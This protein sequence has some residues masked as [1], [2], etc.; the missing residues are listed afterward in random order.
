MLKELFDL[1][2]EQKS[3]LESLLK[4]SEEE[5]HIIINGEAD[6]LEDIV[7]QELRELTKIGAIEKKRAALTP[8]ISAEFGIPEK[9]ITVS[10][11]ARH[12]KPNEREAV[13]KLQ[14]E[15]TNLIK[16]HTEINMENRELIKAHQEYTEA[17][18]DM[19]VDS[20]DPLNNF[21]GD[22][23]KAVSDRKKTTGFFDG[24]A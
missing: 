8:A 21:Y 23:G 1:L 20:E 6:K 19:M 9:D 12:T 5:R 7:R 24:H 14:K 11:I 16:Q 13:T 18:M 4:L 17:F 2:L 15:L 22:D 3:L 10:E